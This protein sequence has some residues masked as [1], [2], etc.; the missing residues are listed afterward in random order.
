MLKDIGKVL[1]YVSKEHGILEDG[2]R[3][4]V[5]CNDAIVIVC[6]YDKTLSIEVLA[7]EPL[8]MDIDLNLL[9]D[10]RIDEVD[11]LEELY[12]EDE[13]DEYKD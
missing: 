2:D 1:D 5:V 9:D 10:I 12:D 4:P 8:E 7:G 6:M 11:D 3:I 13:E